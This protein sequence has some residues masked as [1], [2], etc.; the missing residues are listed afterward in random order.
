VT[1]R[2]AFLKWPY[3]I[4]VNWPIPRCSRIW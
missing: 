1:C 2:L 3:A 4:L